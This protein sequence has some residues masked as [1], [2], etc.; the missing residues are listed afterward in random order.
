[1]RQEYNPE[2]PTASNQAKKN[3]HGSACLPG[4]AE[5][6]REKDREEDGDSQEELEPPAVQQAFPM[7]WTLGRAARNVHFLSYP[8][9]LHV[10]SI[11]R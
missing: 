9:D 5:E 7:P 6:E 4:K 1:M 3:A 8:Y 2:T 11:G 10:F